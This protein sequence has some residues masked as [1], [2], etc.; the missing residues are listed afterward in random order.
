MTKQPGFWDVEER[1]KEI[2]ADGDPLETLAGAVDFER[3]RPILERAAGKP[4]GLKG[5]RPALDVVPEFKM[6]VLQS[7]NGLSLA[8]TEAMVR[9]RPGWMRFCGLELRDKAPDANTLWDFRE[10]LIK[11][12]AHDELFRELDRAINEAGYIPRSGQ[13]VD[14]SLVSA[15]RQRASAG[16]KAAIKA[17][18]AAGEIWPGEPAKAA[19]KDTDARWIVK[20]SKA[21]PQPDG[22]KQ[23]DIAIPVFGYKSHTGIDR[24]HGI[25]RRQI[26]T[27]AGAH[28]GARL[29]EGLVDA[30]NTGSGAWADTACRSR[31]NEDWLEANGTA[32]RIHRRKPRGR[33]MGK[34]TAKANGRKSAVRAKVEHVFAH[35]KSRMG[36]AVRTIGLARARAAITMANM[37]AT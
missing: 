32:S 30:A 26:V 4:P 2:S 15:P 27:D 5:G 29:R 35:R 6:L 21:K 9:D 37:A 36:L 16:E 18:Q 20:H 33:P 1:L 25:I 12:D 28:D 23:V 7:F 8:M 13:I 22:G 14:A 24:K 17:G 19:R 34:R 10:A 11:A 3:F 31:R